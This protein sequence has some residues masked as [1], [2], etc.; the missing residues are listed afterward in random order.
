MFKKEFCNCLTRYADEQK[1]DLLW[2]EVGNAYSSSGRHYH[3]LAHLNNLLAEL[4]PF[5]KLFQ[6]WDTIVFAIAYHDLVYSTLKNDNEEKSAEYATRH[7]QSIGFDTSQTEH[8]RNLILATKEHESSDAETNLFTDAD[9]SILGAKPEDYSVYA[10]QVRKEYN[11]YPDMIYNPG[12]KKVLQ[13]FLSMS[14]IFKSDEFFG[15]Y[16]TTA[17]KNLANELIQLH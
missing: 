5:Q 6:Q 8:C 9:L 13:H 7:L 10:A 1:S 15:T 3:T 14:R 2:R 12:R 17:R 4:K 11:I 16:E